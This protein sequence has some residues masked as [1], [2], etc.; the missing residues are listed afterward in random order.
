MT[1]PHANP[2]TDPGRRLAEALH[3]RAVSSA[4][5]PA[6][7][8]TPRGSSRPRVNGALRR[9]IGWALLV[10]LLAGVALGAGIGLVSLLFPAA[11]PAVG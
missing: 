11:L 8:V 10:A 6:G 9:Q 1:N 5:A 3:A 4:S 7:Y 2:S